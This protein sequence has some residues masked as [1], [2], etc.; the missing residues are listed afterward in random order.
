MV[1]YEYKINNKIVIPKMERSWGGGLFHGQHYKETEEIPLHLVR[2]HRNICTKTHVYKKKKKKCSPPR[3]N[4]IRNVPSQTHNQKQTLTKML[5]L[6][7]ANADTCWQKCAPK[8][9]HKERRQKHTHRLQLLYFV[10]CCCH[11]GELRFLL[12]F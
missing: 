4:K 7:H 12:S 3:P 6:V 11:P 8:K 2:N 5:S 1:L 9:P 10:Y